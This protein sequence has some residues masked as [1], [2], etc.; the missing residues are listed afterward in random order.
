MNNLK[1]ESKRSEIVTIWVKQFSDELFSWAFHKTS[2]RA[3]AEDL[4]QETFIASFQAFDNFLNK[5]S[6]KTWLL[7]ILNNKINDF[8]RKRFRSTY[9]TESHLL[10]ENDNNFYDYFFDDNYK[11]KDERKPGE[12]N[13]SDE[14]LLD[15]TEFNAVLHNCIDKLPPNCFSIIQLKYI[16]EQ[17]GKDIC[18]ELGI[19]QSNYWQIL[20]RAKLQL[21]E[22][23]ENN[24]FKK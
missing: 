21:R 19:S 2:D 22:C 20:H 5:S 10:K 11:W 18:K 24:W 7:S 8:H 15:D 14:I 23:L 3:A 9:K 12:W 16:N 1:Q 13:N 4:V 6:P 17:E